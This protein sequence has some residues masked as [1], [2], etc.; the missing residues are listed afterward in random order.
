MAT[1]NEH[2]VPKDRKVRLPIVP[3]KH[4]A[5][6]DVFL[7]HFL[8]LFELEL[9]DYRVLAMQHRTD[10]F[11]SE[12]KYKRNKVSVVKSLIAYNEQR[13]RRGKVS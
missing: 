8:D 11:E 1:E 5:A 7:N 12:I 13:R 3:E 10:A 9:N 2:T 4:R 6:T